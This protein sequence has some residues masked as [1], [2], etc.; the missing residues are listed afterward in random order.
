MLSELPPQLMDDA[1]F[2]IGRTILTERSPADPYDSGGHHSYVSSHEDLFDL[3][4]FLPKISDD[5]M[6]YCF[7]ESIVES[8]TSTRTKERITRQQRADILQQLSRAIES[9]LPK[10]HGI[11]HDGYKIIAL[12]QIGRLQRLSR[13]EWTAL[14]NRARAVPN[15]ADRVLVL[16]LIA[17]AMPGKERELSEQTIEEAAE[18]IEQIPT[19]LD[20]V[21]RYESIARTMHNPQEAQQYLVTAMKF[22]LGSESPEMYAAQRRMIDLAHRLDPQ[23]AGTLA[24]LADDDPAREHSRNNL[25][26]RLEILNLKKMMIDQKERDQIGSP[27][28]R[29]HCPA[30]SRM[31]LGSLNA[32]RTTPIHFDNTRDF[33]VLAS[34]LPITESLPIL[35]WI[36]ENAVQRYSGTDQATAYI[37]PI[38]DAMVSATRLAAESASRASSKLK[39][40][41]HCSAGSSVTNSVLVSAG[42]RDRAMEHL[43]IWIETSVDE[44]PKICDPYFGPD[45]LEILPVVSATKPNCRVHILTSKRHHHDYT[46]VEHSYR[47]GWRRISD[48]APPVAEITIAGLESS[49]LLPIHDRWWLSKGSGLRIGT[50][51]NSLGGRRESEIS[52]LTPDEATIREME[53]DQ[54]LYRTALEHAG[55]RV[56]YT[57]FNL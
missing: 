1:Y 12:G 27:S 6:I 17:D 53:V 34:E 32:G 20:R 57:T 10:T 45:D 24:S 38:F 19:T 36:V 29:L 3:C 7:V 35:E 50:S 52:Y 51:F 21:G 26:N 37:R 44:Y 2:R 43:R 23:M 55:E 41:D 16:S 5:A 56:L 22:A 48:Q 54:Y 46:S 31:A 25:K 40:I 9:T 39:W 8:M 42:E 4:E 30:A 14:T 11:T 33:A 18:M 15:L 49:G 28:F 47:E 13:S